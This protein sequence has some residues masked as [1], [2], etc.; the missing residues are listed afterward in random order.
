M[1]QSCFSTNYFE[2]QAGA[3]IQL[4]VVAS[5]QEVATIL[6]FEEYD[7]HIRKLFEDPFP[8]KLHLSYHVLLSYIANLFVLT[9]PG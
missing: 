4:G 7:P 9:A 5:N 6:N 3:L 1:L 2:I 8:E